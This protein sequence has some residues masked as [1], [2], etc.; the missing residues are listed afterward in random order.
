MN[1]DLLETRS[2]EAG[3]V[4][5]KNFDS[6]VIGV[7]YDVASQAMSLEF[8]DM[9]ALELN[10]PV[11]GELAAPLHHMRSIQVGIIK[12]GQVQDNR[13][14]PL[15]LLNDSEEYRGYETTV[16]PQK[17][18]TAFE[19]FMRNCNM[20]QPVHRE[21]LGNELSADGVTAGLNRAVLQFAPHLARQKVLE[22]A[23]KAA[24][25]A[26]GPKIGGPGGSGT[27]ASPQSPRPTHK[28]SGN[29]E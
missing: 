5:D 29:D 12:D 19:Y 4:S 10:I 6:P 24:P 28:K 14:V 22:A 11:D 3:L 13:Q 15:M 16:K 1:I 21:D 9:N 23:P 2:G 25:A 27:T 17:S 7:M 20:G 8:A 26:P 18:V